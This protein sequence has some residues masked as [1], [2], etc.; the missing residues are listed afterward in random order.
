MTPKEQAL[1]IYEKMMQSSFDMTEFA[2]LKC[3]KIAIRYI[4]CASP[5]SNPFNTN[6]ISTYDYWIEVEKEINNL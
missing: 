6:G 1:E 2:A 5:H 4:I 3:A